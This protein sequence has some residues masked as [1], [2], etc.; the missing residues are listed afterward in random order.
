MPLLR[1]LASALPLALLLGT[2]ARADGGWTRVDED[3]GVLLERR[4]VAGSS[5]HELRASARSPLPA[6]Q[7]FAA[8][9]SNRQDDPKVKKTVKRYDV[10][11]EDASGRTVYEQVRAPLVSDRDY[12]VRIDWRGEGGHYLVTFRLVNEAGPPPQPGFVRMPE[13]RG[14][15]KIDADPAGGSRVEYVVFSDP[16][17]N[18]AAWIARGAQQGST[19]QNVLD[20]LDYAAAHP[21][22]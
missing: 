20:T 7:V 4:E 12:T 10:L 9:I 15:W 21:V 22:R 19:R 8:V 14:H 5:W 17:G 2:P 11:R 18:I 3:K 16:G 13:V 6:A 1:P